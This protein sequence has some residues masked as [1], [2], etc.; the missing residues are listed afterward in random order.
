LADKLDAGED[1][2]LLDTRGDDS[3]ESWHVRGAEQFEFGTD[4]SLTAG[5]RPLA[6]FLGSVQFTSLPASPFRK[7]NNAI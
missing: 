1:F 4:D 3:Y 6:V 5:R 2:L 7:P